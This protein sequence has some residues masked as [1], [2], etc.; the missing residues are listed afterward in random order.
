MGR[1]QA[2][3]PLLAAGPAV[4]GCGPGSER[5]SEEILPE[6]WFSPVPSEE[7]MAAEGE[8]PA[9]ERLAGRLAAGR[10]RGSRGNRRVSCDMGP[11][12]H[13][14]VVRVTEEGICSEMAGT[15]RSN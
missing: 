8:T 14:A 7:H 2:V 4:E 12:S 15:D 9:D 6:R 1:Q 3:C 11:L 13:N 10:W 5:T